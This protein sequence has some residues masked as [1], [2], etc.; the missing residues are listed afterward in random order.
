MADTEIDKVREIIDRLIGRLDEA[1]P[2]AIRD[3]WCVS[4]GGTD[5]WG[6]NFMHF[7]AVNDVLYLVGG[8]CHDTYRPGLGVDDE[9]WPTCEYLEGYDAGRITIEDLEAAS[10]AFDIA[11]HAFRLLGLD[12]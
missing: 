3:V 8:R 1:L 7:F 9:M 11:D 6:D 10:K 5:T 12:Y 4:D 2:P